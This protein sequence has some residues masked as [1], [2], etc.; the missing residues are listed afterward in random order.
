MHR[1]VADVNAAAEKALADEN[2]RAERQENGLVHKTFAVEKVCHSVYCQH[3]Q[4]HRNKPFERLQIAPKGARETADLLF[5]LVGEGVHVVERQ[6][7][8]N[9]A[10][11]ERYDVDR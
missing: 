5:F 8:R 7:S 11:R 3:D 1:G 4:E 6:R 2:Y 9:A 10:D